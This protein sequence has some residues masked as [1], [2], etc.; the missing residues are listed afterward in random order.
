MRFG[1]GAS[2]WQPWRGVSERG[3]LMLLK[4]SLP[5]LPPSPTSILASSSPSSGIMGGG[6]PFG[7]LASSNIRLE[8]FV[9][10]EPP[11]MLMAELARPSPEPT[12]RNRRN[13]PLE[14][15]ARRSSMM[16]M[17]LRLSGRMMLAAAAA[18][19]SPLAALASASPLAYAVFRRFRLK[20][21]LMLPGRDSVGDAGISSAERFRPALVG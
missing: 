21:R 4:R 16:L 13:H 1:W 18:W 2:S 12:P 19:M 6:G 20:R 11:L 7:F 9:S 3:Y 5:R 17:S 10:G 15:L 14:R 8:R